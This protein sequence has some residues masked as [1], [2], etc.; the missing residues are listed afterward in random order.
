MA[1]LILAGNLNLIGQLNL[2]TTAGGKIKVSSDEVLVEVDLAFK[3]AQGSGTQP[4]LQPPP[5]AVPADL[6]LDVNVIKSFNPT[7][8]ANGKLVVALGVCMQGGSPPPLKWPGMVLPSTK[9]KGAVKINGVPVNVKGDAGLTLP[10]G[11][12]VTFDNRSGQ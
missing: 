2:A 9:N 11:G 7:V 1:D 8:K 3:P 6:G 12:S 5:P 4:V 10:N